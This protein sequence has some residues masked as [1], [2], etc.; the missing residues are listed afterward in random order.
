MLVAGAIIIFSVELVILNRVVEVYLGAF[1][2]ADVILL[3]N[4][5]LLAGATLRFV[6]ECYAS[7]GGS[8][9]TRNH[10]LTV[11]LRRRGLSSIR[12]VLEYRSC[13]L[14]SLLH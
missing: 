11:R 7:S 3:V 4:Y 9:G 8:V 2:L 12:I 5:V 1:V 6:G 13:R 14:H 10:D